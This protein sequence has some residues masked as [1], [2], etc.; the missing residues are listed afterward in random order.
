MSERRTFEERVSGALDALYDGAE[1][2]CG[3]ARRAEALVVSVI[4]E[5]ARV[6][7]PRPPD[8]PGEF[9]K[10]ILAR[11]VRHY[12]DYADSTASPESPA[13]PLA[14]GVERASPPEEPPETRALVEDLARWDAA[15]PERLGA[16]IRGSIAG[17]P[18][19]ERAALWLVNVMDFRYTEAADALGV[20]LGHLR[21][22]L[23]R[24]RRELQLRVAVALREDRTTLGRGGTES[25][26]D[27]R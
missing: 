16:L 11:L 27:A 18:L 1:L 26:R 25:R 4:V 2:L 8:D 6:P 23:Y 19:R 3:E 7:V 5:A 21:Q 17:L 14:P 12:L 22:V 9:R 13:T 15:A 24:A 20:R 10:W